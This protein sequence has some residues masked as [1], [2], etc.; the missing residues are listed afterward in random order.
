MR[1]P[2]SSSSAETCNHRPSTV[3]SAN[4]YC[5]LATST[6]AVNVHTS[7]RPVHGWALVLTSSGFD[8]HNSLSTARGSSWAT[9]Q[10]GSHPG[11]PVAI[12]IGLGLLPL[13]LGLLRVV[14]R[15]VVIDQHCRGIG[16]RHGG[17]EQG[18][19]GLRRPVQYCAGSLALR[20]RS[21]VPPLCA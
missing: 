11:K 16:V 8:N 1:T 15:Q 2:N 19:L 4:A 17:A 7:L 13:G 18:Q 6:T 21:I 14:K 10:A 9:G 5:S 3:A 12:R 20:R